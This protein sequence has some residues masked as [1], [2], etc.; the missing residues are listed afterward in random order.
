VKASPDVTFF[1]KDVFKIDAVR[2]LIEKS[3]LKSFRS[4][5]NESKKFFFI[6]FDSIGFDAQNAFLK[7]LEEPSKGTHFFIITEEKNFLP[8]F[9][10]RVRRIYVKDTSKKGFG[11]DILKKSLPEKF[12]LVEKLCRDI[13]D[14]KKS[15][16]SAIDLVNEIEK[17]ILSENDIVKNKNRLIACQKARE[18][19]SQRGAMIKMILENLMVRI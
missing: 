6:L 19:I 12:S 18:R 16:Q 11:Q 14:E 2:E 8:T 10:S 1:E 9:L 7:L 3:S 4:D 15:K 13:K 17:E 5:E